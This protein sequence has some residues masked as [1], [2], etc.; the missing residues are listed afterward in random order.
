MA[1][2]LSLQDQVDAHEKKII[3]D[4]LERHGYDLPGKEKTAEELNIGLRT[5][6]RK[7][8]KLGIDAK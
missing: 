7:V 2:T 5:L 4:A 8:E 3:I 6:Y 1:P